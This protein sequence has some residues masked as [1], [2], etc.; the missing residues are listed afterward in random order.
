MK[1]RYVNIRGITGQIGCFVNLESF[2]DETNNPKSVS[3]KFIIN[4]GDGDDERAIR[5]EGECL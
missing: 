4:L 2:S 1:R 5:M 3:C